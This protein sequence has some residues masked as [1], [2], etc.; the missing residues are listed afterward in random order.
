MHREHEFNMNQRRSRLLV[1]SHMKSQRPFV[2][3]REERKFVPCG[4]SSLQPVEAAM[5]HLF[6]G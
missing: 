4:F 5:F 2:E 6:T 1:A 3:Q